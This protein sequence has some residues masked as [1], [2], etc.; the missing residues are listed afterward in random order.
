MNRYTVQ[1]IIEGGCIME[2][3]IETWEAMDLLVHAKDFHTETSVSG[4]SIL[5]I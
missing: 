3:K 2:Y 4:I 5:L 1:I